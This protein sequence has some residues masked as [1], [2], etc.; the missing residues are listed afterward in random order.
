M[1]FGFINGFFRSIGGS[2]HQSGGASPIGL[3][4]LCMRIFGGSSTKHKVK[5]KSKS[6][7][8]SFIGALCS[9]GLV[10]VC[11]YAYAKWKS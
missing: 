5:S 1:G 6:K 2:V 10:G 11:K 7:D 9:G 8:A 3:I 4:L